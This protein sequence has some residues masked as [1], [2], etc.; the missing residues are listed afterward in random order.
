VRE[1]RVGVHRPI[2]RIQRG[3]ELMAAFTDEL[4]AFMRHGCSPRD[5]SA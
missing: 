1:Q 4:K 2:R 3:G 5:R